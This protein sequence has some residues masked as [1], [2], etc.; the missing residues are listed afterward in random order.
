MARALI[1]TTEQLF[2]LKARYTFTLVRWF[3][4]YWH[5]LV[6]ELW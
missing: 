2:L 4:V 3:C 1:L 6:S 5:L